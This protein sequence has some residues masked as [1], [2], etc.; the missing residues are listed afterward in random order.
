MRNLIEDVD[1]WLNKNSR[2]YYRDQDA[3]YA[4]NAL[5]CLRDQYWSLTKEPSTDPIDR[6]GKMKMLVGNAVEKALIETILNNLHWF[7]VHL[8][9]SQVAIG[10]SEKGEPRWHGY[11]DA[12][13]AA[14]TDGTWQRFPLEIKTKSGYGADMLMRSMEPSDEYMVQLGL[15]LRKLYKEDVTDVGCLFYVLCSDSNFGSMVQISCRYLPES[16]SIQAYEAFNSKGEKKK[17]SKTVSLAKVFDRWRR[18][19]K[20]VD[21]GK[22]PDPDFQYMYTITPELL[23]T[24]SKTR[25][26]KAAKGEVIVGDWQPK[27]SRFKTKALRVDGTPL[28]YTEEEL[29]MFKN[30]YRRRVPKTKKF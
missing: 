20:A 28:A 17:L 30:E 23:Q 27:Y 26:E 9:G 10:Q 21:E 13:C 25:V 12:L 18:L 16:D 2:P 29:N 22:A 3:H 5:S 24:L 1:R 11:I 6:V 7:G 4:S 19:E 14:K 8:V 15:Y